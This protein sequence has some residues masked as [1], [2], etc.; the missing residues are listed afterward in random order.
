MRPIVALRLLVVATALAVATGA[1]TAVL[2]VFT[3]AR[4]VPSNSFSSG[5]CM[6]PRVSDVQRGTAT[7]AAN[8]TLTVAITAVD[9]TRAFLVFSTSHA[10]NRPG[11][12]MLRGQLSSSTALNF[13]RV[14][15]EVS[16]PP[17]TIEWSV[18]EYEC[19]V[20]VQRGETTMTTATVDV[21]LAA[22]PTDR[23]FVL[24]SKT[25]YAAAGAFGADETQVAEVTGPT[26][27]QLRTPATGG[28]VA[29]Q[30][31]SFTQAGAASVQRGSTSLGPADTAASVPIAS[32]DPSRTF[33]LA[34][35][36]SSTASGP[37]MGARMVRVELASSTS[38]AV[39]RSTVGSSRPIEEVHWQ[40]VELLD[41]SQ[42]QSGVLE[43]TAA[44]PS[45]DVALPRAVDL[46]R[47]TALGSVQHGSGQNAGRGSYVTDDMPGEMSFS[48]QL[49]DAS[50]LRVTRQSAVDEASVAWS[51]VEW[52]RAHT[53]PTCGLPRVRDI[54]R[55]T[56]TTAAHET[57][58][59]PIRRVDPAKAFLLF[60]MASSDNNPGGATVRGLLDSTGTALEFARNTDE[61]APPPIDIAWTVVEY[62]CGVRVQRGTSLQPSLTTNVTISPVASLDRAFVTFSKA[63]ARQQINWDGDDAVAVDLVAV[64]TLQ[65]TTTATSSSQSN[66]WQVV[67]FLT[68]G[69]I[70]VQRGTTSLAGAELTTTVTLSTPVD[71]SRTIVLVSIA[72]SGSGGDIGSRMVRARL[73]GP[74][75][76][77]VERSVTGSPDPIET[78]SWQVIQLNDGSRVLSG[79]ETFAPGVTTRDLTIGPVDLR[80]AVSLA[81]FQY[82][83]GQSGG[84]TSYTSY[85]IPGEGAWSTRLLSGNQLRLTRNSS[86]AEGR[87]Q[88]QVVEWGQP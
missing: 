50:T 40:V 71:P 19:G 42:V 23:S 52:G 47:A 54:Q 86:F 44:V 32:A 51:V 1:P 30:V 65:I 2:G 48:L 80:R 7:S 21:T 46:R 41:G 78:I 28:I 27:L 49:A 69:S 70:A 53:S 34:S 33:V 17:I 18:V 4:S 72:S 88:W 87:V 3:A 6:L 37:D 5:G 63:P 26:T 77:V 22:V 55:G 8:G 57:I 29:W 15:D 31:V 9:P 35:H 68:P 10:S 58:T 12:S 73:T 64:N 75:T 79:S 83:G 66:A 43:Q 36:Q 11:S 85:D 59:V 24:F 74:S 39:S 56:A 76:L 82:A 61:P 81:T 38:L 62:E 25:V 13:T 20:L 67:E 60:T 16:P 84:M 45:S 14:T